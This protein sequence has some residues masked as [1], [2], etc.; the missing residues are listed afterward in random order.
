MQT[1]LGN[2]VL[3]R[4]ES[5]I[6]ALEYYYSVGF[7]ET[8]NFARTLIRETDEC[9]AARKLVCDDVKGLAGGGGSMEVMRGLIGAIRHTCTSLV[10]QAF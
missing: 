6:Q 8:I 7:V 2:Q 9:N 1:P 3:L 4:I 10:R 5:R